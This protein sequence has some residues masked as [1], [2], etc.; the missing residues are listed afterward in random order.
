VEA[1]TQTVLARTW[2]MPAAPVAD[3]PSG[4]ARGTRLRHPLVL[5]GVALAVAAAAGAS[6][7]LVVNSPWQAKPTASPTITR[8]SV[9]QAAKVAAPTPPAPVAS[10]ASQSSSAAQVTDHCV[11]GTFDSSSDEFYSMSDI[12]SGEGATSGDTVAEAYQLTLTDSQSSGPVEITGF[13][14][15]FYSNGQELTSDSESLDEPTFITPGQS[16]TWTEH[17]W[18][19]SSGGASIGPFAAGQTGAVDPGAT[20]ELINQWRALP[21][22]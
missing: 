11:T 16:L 5:V 3:F 12:T 22:R 9:T 20:C 17:P 8:T 6:A 7:G 13:A 19:Y 14:I 10:S 2:L 21:R 18:G 4:A 15:A 1:R